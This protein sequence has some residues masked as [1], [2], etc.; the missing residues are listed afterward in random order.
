MKTAIV[1]PARWNSSRMPGKPLLKE[2]GK[3]LIQ[4]VYEQCYKASAS[5]VVVATDDHRIVDAV[6]LFGGKAVMTSPNHVSGTDRVAEVA[7]NLNADIIVNVQGDEPLVDPE[8]IDMVSRLIEEAGPR[9]AMATL[10]SPIRTVEQ[11]LDPSC[12][13]VVCNNRGQAIYFSRSPIPHVRDNKPDL[14]S[15]PSRFLQHI[16]IYAYTKKSLLR[17]SSMKPEPLEEAEQLEQLRAIQAGFAIKVGV[18]G[19]D[20]FGIDTREDYQRFSMWFLSLEKIVG[21]QKQDGQQ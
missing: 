20:G 18:V 17:L 19:H 1:I 21:K 4:H 11:W 16:G 10:A 14:K 2:T 13:K 6:E 9:T 5:T 8:H 7:A 3:Y 15:R 12:V